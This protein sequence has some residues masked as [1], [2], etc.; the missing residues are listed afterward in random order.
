VYNARGFS[1]SAGEIAR[2]VR[3]SFPGAS[4]RFAPV[5]ERQA[6]VDTWPADVDDRAARADWG[7]APAHD[8]EGAIRDYLAPAL[9]ARYATSKA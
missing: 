1:A 6:L 4:I 7:F 5:A 2:A 3:A 8:L 9:R